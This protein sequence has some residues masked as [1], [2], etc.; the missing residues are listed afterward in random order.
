[1]PAAGSQR[2]SR[3]LHP[4][5]H[6][7]RVSLL[8][9]VHHKWHMVRFHFSTCGILLLSE[10]GSVS[11]LPFSASILL[12]SFSTHTRTHTHTLTGSSRKLL[13]QI[14]RSSKKGQKSPQ[15]KKTKKLFVLPFLKFFLVGGQASCV[16]VYFPA[17]FF[18]HP[19][20]AS[21][22]MLQRTECHSAYA[23]MFFFLSG[24]PEIYWRQI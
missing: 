7:A 3:G 4:P 14:S 6:C 18:S 11:L 20:R 2:S 13:A 23:C 9:G 24:S 16:I 1:M 10:T 21:R 19:C 17:L 8:S 5:L 12:Q 22:H 15:G